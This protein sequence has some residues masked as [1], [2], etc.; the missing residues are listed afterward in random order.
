MKRLAS[1][2]LFLLMAALAF[3]G[4]LRFARQQAEAK[5]EKMNPSEYVTVYT[6]MPSGMLEALGDS[7]YGQRA[8]NECGVSV[9]I[10]AF[11]SRKS[12]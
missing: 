5:A 7:L 6:D 8:E 2:F 12:G 3:W 10:P 4:I 1:V 9:Q 11:K